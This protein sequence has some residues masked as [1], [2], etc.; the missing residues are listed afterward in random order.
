MTHFSIK[1]R[2]KRLMK[3]VHVAVQE[4]SLEAAKST[5]EESF[6]IEDSAILT[7]VRQKIP[8]TTLTEV[9]ETIMLMKPNLS[10]ERYH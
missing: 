9:R 7:R 6:L 3:A 10:E 8:N 2:S 5:G 4:L 1:R